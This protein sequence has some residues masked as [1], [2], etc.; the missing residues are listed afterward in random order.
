MKSTGTRT[1]DEQLYNIY[2]G[3]N[4]TPQARVEYLD[5]NDVWQTLNDIT[6]V[7]MTKNLDSDIKSV[8]GLLPPAPTLKLSIDNNKAQYTP[9]SGSALDGI[10]ALGRKVRLKMGYVLP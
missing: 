6:S 8:Y 4:M 9:G 7:S 2:E 10:I 1:L 5:D 3:S